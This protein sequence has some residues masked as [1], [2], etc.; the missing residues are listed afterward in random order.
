M[1]DI[2][3]TF[4]T[5]WPMC[6]ASVLCSDPT[7]PS[8]SRQYQQS[9]SNRTSL[10]RR[11]R[12]LLSKALKLLRPRADTISIPSGETIFCEGDN[13]ANVY[14]VNS[15]VARLCMTTLQCG[16]MIS[17]FMLT[18]E[19][20]G[21]IGQSSY[22]WTAEAATDIELLRLSRVEADD[23]LGETGDKNILVSYAWQ[24]AADAWRFQ[25]SMVEQTPDQRLACFLVK[26]SQRSGT[27][28]GLPINLKIARRDIACHL[29][30]S[31]QEL[32]ASFKALAGR[33][34]IDTSVAGSCTILNPT[35]IIG[36]ALRAILP[37][38][39]PK[40]RRF[41]PDLGSIPV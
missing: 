1:G 3:R 31:A 21:T 15:G 22:A 7:L 19:P 33:R 5:G 36:L 18:D 25:M 9:A 20:L 30:I 27:P 12:E 39:A 17:D 41:S 13:A 11:Q 6:S 10:L 2:A 23:L 24:L 28:V 40:S 4:K 35:A 16:R 26:F 14:I 32:S 8:A 29:G 37:D 34:V 38:G